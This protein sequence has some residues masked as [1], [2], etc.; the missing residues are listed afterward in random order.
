MPTSAMPNRCVRC[1]ASGR[2]RRGTALLVMM[3]LV[4][5]ALSLSYAAMRG[6]YTTVQIQRNY[7]R[8]SDR[9]SSAQ[10]AALIGMSLALKRMHV[11]ADWQGVDVPWGR[12]LG[13]YEGFNVTYRTGDSSLDSDHPDYE[14]FPYRVTVSVTGY[15]AE[16]DDPSRKLTH[17]VRAVVRLVPRYLGDEPSDWATMQQ[18]TVYQSKKDNFEIDIPCRIEG[19]VRVQAKFE[20]AK[21]YP[22]DNNAWLRYL[23]DLNAMRLAGRPDYRPIDGPV[24]LSFSEQTGKYLSVITNQLAVTAN[25]T[26]PDEAAA[27]WKKPVSL[28]AYQIYDGGPVYNIP[29][30]AGTLENIA[31][32]PDPSTNPLGIYY[33]GASVTVRSGVTIEGSLFCLGDVRIE[34]TNVRFR[35]VELPA[36]NGSDGSVRLPVVSCQNFTVKSTAGGSVTGLAAVFDR[37][38]VDKSPDSVAF[39]VTGRL[40]ARK[41]LLKERQPWEIEDWSK[42]YNEYRDDLDDPTTAT[43]PYFPIWLRYRGGLGPKPQLTVKP[44]PTPVRYHWHNSQNPVYVP[45]PDDDGLRWELLEWAD[46]GG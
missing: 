7:A 39:A 27:D 30:V 26:P 6:Q 35:P 46:V 44:D 9:R 14:E 40:I 42:R 23:G 19:A 1:A 34:G 17:Q 5:I 37:F 8:N 31:L 24:D 12:P 3:L 11:A 15:A 36:L 13:E 32:G 43:T 2:R 33:C 41:F 20:L 21:H 10:L 38:Q 28:T 29:T 16:P 4:S 45:H 18:Y 22:N 25:D